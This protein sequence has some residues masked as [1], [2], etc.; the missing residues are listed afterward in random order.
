MKAA[1]VPKIGGKW[2]VREVQTPELSANQV[3]IKIHASR[4]CYIDVHIT[5]GRIPVPIEKQKK[6]SKKYVMSVCFPVLSIW[7]AVF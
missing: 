2:K 4:L 7:D 3:L 5:E 6:Q 1:V